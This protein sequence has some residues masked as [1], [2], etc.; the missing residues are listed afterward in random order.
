MNAP[1]AGTIL[2]EL[3]RRSYQANL[4]ALGDI[5]DEDRDAVVR[6]L[7]GVSP[8]ARVDVGLL[9]ETLR[10]EAQ[11]R[12]EAE[13]ERLKADADPWRYEL[14]LKSPEELLALRADLKRRVDAGEGDQPFR[15]GSPGAEIMDR[16]NGIASRLHAPGVEQPDPGLDDRPPPR[17]KVRRLASRR[18]AQS[19]PEAADAL[20]PA[21]PAPAHAEPASARVPGRPESR[22]SRLLGPRAFIN[23]EDIGSDYVEPF[24]PPWI[25]PDQDQHDAA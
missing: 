19:A 14:L 12:A 15:P 4:S 6:A 9:I 11:E 25:I 3:D 5:A 16:L 13:A 18:L 22:L 21:H 10:N 20:E 17:P 23:G 24:A 1:T 7:S 2:R 8:K